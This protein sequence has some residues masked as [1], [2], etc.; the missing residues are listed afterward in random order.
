M[1]WALSID[2]RERIVAYKEEGKTDAEIAEAL[3][4]GDASVSRVLRRF[5]ETGGVAPAKHK[6]RRPFLLDDEDRAVLVVIVEAAPDSTLSE[7]V[8]ELFAERGKKV[9]EATMGRD[10]RRCGFT[11][12]K[13]V[14]S[15]GTE[16]RT[17]CRASRTP[18][19]VDG[20]TRR[21]QGPLHR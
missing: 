1:A 18:R 5:R 14:G 10:L 6:G 11:R 15:A 20:G 8:D 7:L 9:S 16:P 21:V 13:D 3:K 17:R 19:R 12:K 2:I 4:I